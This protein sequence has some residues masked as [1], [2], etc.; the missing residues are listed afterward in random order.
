MSGDY[1]KQLHGAIYNFKQ[2][3]EHIDS[4]LNFTQKN[5]EAMKENLI[6]M[7]N[8]AAEAGKC[9]HVLSRWAY[10]LQTFSEEPA[11]GEGK[12]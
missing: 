4:I 10:G 2:D 11:K 6:G 9:F 1:A 8:F 3:I 7:E 12:S 5:P